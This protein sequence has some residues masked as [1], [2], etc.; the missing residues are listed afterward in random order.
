[1][2]KTKYTFNRKTLSYEKV[3][4]TFRDRVFKVFSYMLICLLFSSV[5]LVIGFAV[6]DSPKAKMLNRQIA[7]LQLKYDLLNIQLARANKGLETLESHDN[8]IYRPVL[9][10]DSIP[11][12]VRQ[13]GFGGADRYRDLQGYANSELMTKTAR[14]MDILICELYVQSKSYDELEKLEKNKTCLED[15]I[16]AITPIGSS[17]SEGISS[18]FGWRINPVYKIKEFH[19]GM[20]FAA[21]E[22]TPIHATGDGVVEKADDLEQGYGN[23]VEINHGFGYETLYAH[24]S[25]IAVTVGQRVKRGQVIGYVGCTGLCTGAHVHY[26]VIKNG[27]YVNPIDYFYMNLSS[28]EYKIIAKTASEQNQALD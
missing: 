8:N 17:Q 5:V 3:N 15:C 10:I 22:G 16:P 12:S 23:C 14:K 28:E 6:I 1:M 27:K 9:N 11:L 2:A 21:P 18:G 26:G 7:Q 20:D 24:M 25:R 13:A 4:H 19:A